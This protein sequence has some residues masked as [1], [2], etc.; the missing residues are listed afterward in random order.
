M[1]ADRYGERDRRP[2]A[3]PVETALVFVVDGDRLLLQH[4]RRE[5]NAGLVSPPGGKLRPGEEPI[6]AARRELLEETGIDLP[7]PRFE[8]R[9]TVRHDG[10]G[11]DEVWLQHLYRVELPGGSEAPPR[12][13][14]REGA[15]TWMPIRDVLEERAAMPPADRFY[16]P[17]V[18]DRA[19][20]ALAW[21][22]VHRPD[23]SVA[24]VAFS[25]GRDP[26]PD[27]G[28]TAR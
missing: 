8:A 2:T 23:G 17:S 1:S 14:E 3:R 27:D 6:A 28:S 16:F 25:L 20:A 24:S 11:L 12:A 26:K 22:V 15:F 13:C 7:I 21:H 5:P 18:L 9:G 19:R 4:R 10:P